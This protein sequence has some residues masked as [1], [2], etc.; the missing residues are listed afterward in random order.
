MLLMDR[1]KVKKFVI[2][3]RI[4]VMS[5]GIKQNRQQPAIPC[6]FT[7]PFKIHEYKPSILDQ[8]F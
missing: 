3:Q 1:T 4:E 8:G 7:I 2:G 5:L 6:V